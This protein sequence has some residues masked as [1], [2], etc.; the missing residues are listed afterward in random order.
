MT[1]LSKRARKYGDKR[2]RFREQDEHQP[3][4][5][6][7][8][9]EIEMTPQQKLKHAILLKAADLDDITLCEAVTTDNVDRLYEQK[10]LNGE[11]QDARNE[12]RCCGEKTSLKCD[13]SRHYESEATAARMPDGTWVGWTYWYGGGKHSEPEEVEWIE[14][15]Y[16]LTMEEKQVT[17]TRRTFTKV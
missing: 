6:G 15:A 1:T 7:F 4:D 5:A 14:D 13:W 16:D 10:D 2:D 12:I 11:L 8:F 3:A 17:V 9:L